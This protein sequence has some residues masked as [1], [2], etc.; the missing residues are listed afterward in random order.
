MQFET[1]EITIDLET[2]DIAFDVYSAV[3]EPP[4][5]LVLEQAATRPD[6]F[7]WHSQYRGRTFEEVYQEFLRQERQDFD[8][9]SW[10]KGARPSQVARTRLKL[11][12]LR[13]ELR[14]ANYGSVALEDATAG[15]EAQH[16]RLVEYTVAGWEAQ[17]RHLPQMAGAE[18]RYSVSE[19]SYPRARWDQELVDDARN[20]RENRKD[21]ILT[22]AMLIIFA[23]ALI[24]PCILITIGDFQ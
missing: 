12:I 17:Y 6:V 7:A 22:V 2:E 3:P 8:R 24:T 4:K 20:Y 5:L 10:R 14:Q 16:R 9:V 11:E 19:S 21:N 15:W 18:Q 1:E 23:I 13:E